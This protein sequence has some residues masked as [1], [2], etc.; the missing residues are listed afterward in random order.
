M[1]LLRWRRVDKGKVKGVASVLLPIGLEIHE[2][3]ILE[4]AKG[5]FA[6]LPSR[7]EMRD[8][9]ALKDDAGR[10]RYTILLAWRKRALGDEFSRR[11]LDLIAAQHPGEV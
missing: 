1:Q 5:A 11:L 4:G 3:L 6:M 2:I 7:P 9:R 8:G 10:P